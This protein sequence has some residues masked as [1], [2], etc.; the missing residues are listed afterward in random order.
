MQK[1]QQAYNLIQNFV[2]V[3]YKDKY[4]YEPLSGDKVPKTYQR[5]ESLN[6]TKDQGKEKKG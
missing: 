4:A 2:I 3:D 6:P 1:C 5:L